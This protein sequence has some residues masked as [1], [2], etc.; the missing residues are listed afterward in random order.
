MFEIRR[1]LAVVD[2]TTKTQLALTRA[3][4]LAQQFDAELVLFVCDYQYELGDSPFLSTSSGVCQH[5]C[6]FSVFRNL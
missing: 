1:I 3:V 2:P 5:S 4:E 6:A